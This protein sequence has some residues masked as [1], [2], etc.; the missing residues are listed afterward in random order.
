MPSYPTSPTII[1]LAELD[2]NMIPSVGGKGAN[3]GELLKAGFS[4]PNGFAVTTTAFNQTM[5]ANEISTALSKMKASFDGLD[6]V[7]L[8]IQAHE[9][10]ALILNAQIPTEILS[11]VRA[12][13]ISLDSP[14]VAVRSSATM[15]DSASA[16]FA[17]Q[18][19][20]YLNIRSEVELTTALINCWA[21]LYEPRTVVYRFE[22]GLQELP[23]E[24]GVVVQEMINP[25][26]SGVIFTIDPVTGKHGTLTIDS[27]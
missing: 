21:S 20:T 15:E 22:K 6:V 8:E 17:G 25:D 24:M 12:A 7:K 2:A 1:W 16:S 27:L 9:T 14:L 18:H 4:V 26:I 19:G 23:L 13:F 3:L 11:P 5:E 10:Q